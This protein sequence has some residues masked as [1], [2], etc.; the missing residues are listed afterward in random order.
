ML[1]TK[2]RAVLPPLPE[3]RGIRAARIDDYRRKTRLMHTHSGEKREKHA[4]LWAR[5]PDDWYVE[6]SECSAALFAMETFCGEVW[7]PACGLG[8]IVDEAIRA[9]HRAVGTD[10][11]CR[12]QHCG[13]TVDF[14]ST[15]PD[16]RFVNIVSNPPF[17]IAEDFVRHALTM[18]MSGGK[19]AMILPIVWLA[20]FSKKRYWLPTSPLR[21]VYPISPRPS[22]PPGAVIE[23]GIRPG[24]GEKDYAWF[25]W[26]NGHPGS[27]DVVFMDTSKYRKKA[28]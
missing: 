10:I 13:S 15:S 24:N 6:P 27:A 21:R 7:D 16:G 2:E 4:H 25:V 14:L 22:M 12:S 28:K 5:D 19:V 26:Q 8:R 11:V 3:G 18:V 20:G 9:G 17:K 1:K 23:A